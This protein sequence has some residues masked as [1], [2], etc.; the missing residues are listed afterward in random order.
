MKSGPNWQGIN[1]SGTNIDN[2]NELSEENV[3]IFNQEGDY[4]NFNQKEIRELLLKSHKQTLEKITILEL[5]NRGFNSNCANIIARNSQKWIS[6]KKLD[7]SRNNLLDVDAEKIF[8]N[9]SW[10][11]LQELIL[12]S[13]KISYK[14]VIAIASST[15]W[16]KLRK[17]YL[18]FNCIDSIS[19]VVLGKNTTWS[20]LEE[21]VLNNNQLDDK[22]TI[23]IGKNT[24]WKNLK[25]LDLGSNQIGDKGASALAKNSTWRYLEELNLSD[26]KIGDVGAV[27]IGSNQ[28]WKNLKILSLEANKI[29]DAGGFKIAR[30]RAWSKLEEL[31][32]YNNKGFSETCLSEFRANNWKQLRILIDDIKNFKLKIDLANSLVSELVDFSS[33]KLEDSDAIA[34]RRYRKGGREELMLHDN[35]I[36]DEGA[37]S[38]GSNTTWLNLEKLYLHNNLIK[39]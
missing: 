26:N 9:S 4:K 37:I 15:N 34:L 5:K 39:K 7:L 33:K 23:A 11:N 16:Q 3:L 28:L 24:T 19:G 8:K 12:S 20:N 29:G 17:L 13:N 22:G 25:R 1:L 2:S 30:N 32:I 21:L 6:L 27:E 14:T 38:I 31:Y 10:P 35:Y 36:G 18:D